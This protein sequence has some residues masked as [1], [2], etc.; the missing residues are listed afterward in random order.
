MTANVYR[1]FQSFMTAI[2]Y[3]S[4]DLIGRSCVTL[5]GIPIC[6]I[7]DR[8]YPASPL[9]EPLSEALHY[10]GRVSTARINPALTHHVL[11]LDVRRARKRIFRVVILICII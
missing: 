8:D 5:S 1:Q 2:I 9:F 7:S 10:W 6:A 4:L 3:D 11:Y